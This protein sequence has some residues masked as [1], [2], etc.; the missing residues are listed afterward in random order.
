MVF[1]RQDYWSGLPCPPLGDFPDLGIL[2]KSLSSVLAGGF[3]TTIA[4]WEALK[5]VVVS[6]KI[7]ITYWVLWTLRYYDL[8]LTCAFVV[9]S[10]PLVSFLSHQH[11]M[12]FA[13]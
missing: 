3:L 4:T 9:S 13:W 10:S 7:Q 1:S 11:T 12:V 2:Q 6:C 5:S 8:S